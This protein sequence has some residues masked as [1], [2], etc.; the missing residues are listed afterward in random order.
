MASIWYGY[1]LQWG[2]GTETYHA[3]WNPFLVLVHIYIYML[4]H[5]STTSAK[6]QDTTPPTHKHTYTPPPH[7]PTKHYKGLGLTSVRYGTDARVSVRSLIDVDPMVFV[8]WTCIYI[9]MIMIPCNFMIQW[10]S[11]QIPTQSLDLF[12]HCTM[13]QYFYKDS[14]EQAMFTLAMIIPCYDCLMP[15]KKL[16]YIRDFSN[17]MQI[18][19]GFRIMLMAHELGRYIKIPSNTSSIFK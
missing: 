19:H 15:N 6:I 1:K 18:D 2:G 5:K 8:I 7:P 12:N 4:Y 11:R 17:D 13:I 10:F 9:S 3:S 14:L 16:A